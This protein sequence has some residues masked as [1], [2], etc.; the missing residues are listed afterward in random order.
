MD[1]NLCARIQTPVT[2][3]ILNRETLP[4]CVKSLEDFGYYGDDLDSVRLRKCPTCGTYFEERSTDHFESGGAVGASIKKIDK[5][6]ALEILT[7]FFEKF[8][9]AGWLNARYDLAKLKRE[10]KRLEAS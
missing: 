4:D 9:S 7:K 2:V 8:E 1:C 6:R 5:S 3:D 10:R